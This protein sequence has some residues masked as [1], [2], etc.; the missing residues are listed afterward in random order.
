[1][2]Q[3]ASKTDDETCAALTCHE[4]GA[5]AL[6]T[7]PTLAPL[8]LRDI[9]ERVVQ[10]EARQAELRMLRCAALTCD[11]AGARALATLPTVAP[12]GLRHIHERVV[13][14]EAS[15]AAL[16]MLRQT[17]DLQRLF[18]EWE[19]TMVC[20]A[21]DP[22]D[23][24]DDDDDHRVMSRVGALAHPVLEHVGGY[25]TCVGRRLSAI[26]VSATLSSRLFHRCLGS[27]AAIS[28]SDFNLPWLS[29]YDLLVGALL[30]DV[31]VRASKVCW[32]SLGGG[33]GEVTADGGKALPPA[34]SGDALMKRECVKFRADFAGAEAR[35][36]QEHRT[37]L[38]SL[39]EIV[40]RCFDEHSR[41]IEKNLKIRMKKQKADITR[42]FAGQMEA[43]KR[44]YAAEL[45]PGPAERAAAALERGKAEV[46]FQE[47]IAAL[48]ARLAREAS[49]GNEQHDLTPQVAAPLHGSAHAG[50]IGGAEETKQ[51]EGEEEEEQG[52]GAE[53]TKGRKKAKTRRGLKQ[54]GRR[55]PQ[56]QTGR[57]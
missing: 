1:M 34:P 51:E 53:E 39:H 19:G 22:D 14:A 47:T 57:Q 6:A 20:H 10:A 31:V 11:E 50:G 46:S 43:L 28:S 36:E 42:S 55:Q 9:H 35:I 48:K 45:E 56:P 40:Q 15:R 2:S 52:A 27:M 16:E 44:K 30:V 37:G 5:C 21:I 29:A 8:D 49:E 33:G 25:V 54:G 18:P 32:R 17:A 7:L 26:N 13:L 3:R 23:D 41:G 38:E 4:A 12:L 24:D